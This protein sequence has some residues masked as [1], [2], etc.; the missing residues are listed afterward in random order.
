MMNR[1]ALS[2]LGPSALRQVDA[3]LEAQRIRDEMAATKKPRSKYGAVKTTV[4][5]ITFDSKAEARRWL[6][7]RILLRAGEITNLEVHKTFPIV[8][9]GVPV[10]MNN[11]HVAKYTADFVY[12]D[13]AGKRIVEDVKGFVVRDFPLRRAIIEHI[14]NLKIVEVRA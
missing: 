13:K 1:I 10:K 2:D 7:L 5:G 14:Y 8:I 11:G 12:F 4:D 9:N 3:C 6:E